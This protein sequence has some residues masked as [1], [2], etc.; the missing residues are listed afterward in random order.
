MIHTA[1]RTIFTAPIGA[2]LAGLVR[3][4]PRYEREKG[5]VSFSRPSPDGEPV[6]SKAAVALQLQIID[7]LKHTPQVLD[8]L[9]SSKI[10]ANT[11]AEAVGG[12]R[13]TV[14]KALYFMLDTG[15]V[16]KSEKVKKSMHGRRCVEW[17]VV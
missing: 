16:R 11:I 7:V 15:T 17:E 1:H 5:V 2:I 13:S 4:V 14:Y 8:A 10:D 3:D 12:K 6:L 9:D